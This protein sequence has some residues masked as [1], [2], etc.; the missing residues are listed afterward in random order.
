MANWLHRYIRR[1]AELSQGVDSNL[2]PDNRTRWLRGTAAIAVAFA[3]RW[4][5]AEVQLSGITVW[6]VIGLAIALL[7]YGFFLLI[8]TNEQSA[9]LDKPEPEKPLTLFKR[10]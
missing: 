10:D 5:A 7:L 3:L 1:Q 8:W 6:V 2:L 9:F 4:L